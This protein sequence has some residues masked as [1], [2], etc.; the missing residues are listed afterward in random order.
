MQLRN[1]LTKH[2]VQLKDMRHLR[3]HYKIIISKPS[4]ANSFV[5]NKA[6]SYLGLLSY[7]STITYI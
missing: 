1:H 3:K 4:I 2:N 5:D 6:V 7:N